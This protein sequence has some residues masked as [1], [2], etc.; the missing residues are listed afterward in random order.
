M[1]SLNVILALATAMILVG[2]LVK[3]QWSR[4]DAPRIHNANG[5]PAV[6]ERVEGSVVSGRISASG[7]IEG[8][9]ANVEIR[10]RISEQIQ[11]I[12]VNEGDWVEKGDDPGAV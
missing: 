10:S 11:H 7:W 2:L 1:K 8:R 12:S 3:S 9:T 5:L 4:I 6:L